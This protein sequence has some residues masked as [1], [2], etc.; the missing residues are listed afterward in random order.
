M[1]TTINSGHVKGGSSS[2]PSPGLLV[3]PNSSPSYKEELANEMLVMEETLISS[4]Q[5][6][7]R[8]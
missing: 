4:N 1:S 2:A 5:A 3:S 7:I 8:N 6:I